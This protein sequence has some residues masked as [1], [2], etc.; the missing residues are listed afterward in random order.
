[1]TAYAELL[2]ALKYLAYAVETDGPLGLPLENALR[3]ISEA[4]APSVEDDGSRHA[5][6][7]ETE[8]GR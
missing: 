7:T 1:V 2:E 5:D 8:I 6:L 4:E 3:V